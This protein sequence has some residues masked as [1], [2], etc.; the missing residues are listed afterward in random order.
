MGEN[1]GLSIPGVSSEGAIWIAII[2]FESA[3][4]L[5]FAKMEDKYLITYDSTVE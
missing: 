4:I 3:N 5:I 2:C 1:Y